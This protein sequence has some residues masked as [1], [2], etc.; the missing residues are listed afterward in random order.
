[1]EKK[2]VQQ[3]F[4]LPVTAAVHDFR[5]RAYGY[6]ITR[7]AE[8]AI[9][10][11][12]RSFEAQQ[13]EIHMPRGGKL[14][15]PA[16]EHFPA[17]LDDRHPGRPTEEETRPTSPDGRELMSFYLPLPIHERMKNVIFWTRQRQTYFIEDAVRAFLGMPPAP[18]SLLELQAEEAKVKDQ[19]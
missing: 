4:N 2:K 5:R 6:D 10:E 1:M 19:D 8:E 15:K 7:I 18:K 16:G 3:K 11:H 17:R 13:V 14:I 9:V 12:L